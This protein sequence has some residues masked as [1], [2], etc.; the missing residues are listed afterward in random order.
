[1]LLADGT[2]ILYSDADVHRLIS[3]I[4]CEL[5]QLYTWFSINKLS[6][7]VSK[8]NYTIFSNRIINFVIDVRIRNNQ[9]TR[10]F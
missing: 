9:M 4:N 1:M 7:N 6:L 3:V 2:T 5:G 10:E 8:T